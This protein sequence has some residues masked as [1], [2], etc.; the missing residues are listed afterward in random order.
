MSI[1]IGQLVHFNRAVA[2][3]FR[4]DVAAQMKRR[5]SEKT[6]FD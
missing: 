3:L 1:S 2:V 4:K 5:R 6:L